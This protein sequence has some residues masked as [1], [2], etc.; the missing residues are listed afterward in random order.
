MLRRIRNIF[1]EI[2]ILCLCFSGCTKKTDSDSHSHSEPKDSL[3]EEWWE[4]YDISEDEIILV[5]S[6][7]NYAW[8]PVYYGKFVTAN[9]NVYDFNFSDLCTE[10]SFDSDKERQKIKENE[11]PSQTLKPETVNRLFTS[12]CSIDAERRY[13]VEN[14]AMDAGGDYIYSYVNGRGLV[15]IFEV[16][17]NYGFYDEPGVGYIVR[18]CYDEFDSVLVFGEWFDTDDLPKM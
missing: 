16:G 7:A 4:E 5:V 13:D 17:D 10:S 2:I 3:S 9:G 6:H 14:L 8:N 18:F 12:G 15:P 1:A 11:T